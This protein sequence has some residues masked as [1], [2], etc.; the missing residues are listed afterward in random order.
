MS[1]LAPPESQPLVLLEPSVASTVRQGR[2]GRRR[3]GVG[4]RARRDC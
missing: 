1:V 4:W 2:R 3:A